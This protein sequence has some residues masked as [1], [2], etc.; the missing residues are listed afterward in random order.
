MSNQND[1]PMMIVGKY[2]GDDDN[3]SCVT[4]TSKMT[5][6]T[7]N[8]SDIERELLDLPNV[9]VRLVNNGEIDE[10]NEFIM[11]NFTEDCMFQSPTMDTPVRGIQH[12]L[13]TAK[14][15]M[16]NIPDFMISAD[17]IRLINRET[18]DGKVVSP[19]CIVFDRHFLGKY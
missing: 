1:E 7:E 19:G 18:K 14:G 9:F 6:E 3:F 16:Q 2:D 15:V 10:L 8:L 13:S 4:S 17:D 11:K 5:Y 12:I